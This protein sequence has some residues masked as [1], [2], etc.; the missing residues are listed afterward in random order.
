MVRRDPALQPIHNEVLR[1]YR[2]VL[3]V[4]ADAPGRPSKREPQ[5]DPPSGLQIQSIPAEL[6]ADLLRELVRSAYVGGAYRDVAADLRAAQIEARDSAREELS[7]L[8]R[9][10][11]GV[12]EG[13][14][15]DRERVLREAAAALE[16]TSVEL[17]PTTD[18][19]TAQLRTEVRPCAKS[20]RL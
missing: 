4:K 5:P 20:S 9:S 17:L 7:V 10:L 6:R 16:T 18:E 19:E 13:R 1:R 3:G 15:L 2:C 11:E 8:R 14:A 12:R